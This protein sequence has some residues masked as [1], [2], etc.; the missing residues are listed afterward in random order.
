M[1][2]S[3]DRRK[4]VLVFALFILISLVTVSIIKLT[5][6]TSL[7]SI[8]LFS[9]TVVNTAAWEIDR[10]G[11]LLDLESFNQIDR[12]F[13][14]QDFTANVN[15][16]VVRYQRDW[17]VNSAMVYIALHFEASG[18]V[19]R[20]EYVN[21]TFHVNDMNSHTIVS[22]SNED[23]NC[24]V[25]DQLTN[26]GGGRGN[27]TF[28]VLAANSTSCFVARPIQWIFFDK[29]SSIPHSMNVTVEC[30]YKSGSSDKKVVFPMILRLLK[31][32]G[33]GFS[34]A[35]NVS[36]GTYSRTVDNVDFSDFFA[37]ELNSSERI[38]VSITAPYDTFL[39]YTLFDP[40]HVSVQHEE[41]NSTSVFIYDV[42]ATGTWYIEAEQVPVGGHRSEG[43]YVI[44]IAEG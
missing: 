16:K 40:D 8:G 27:D 31:D 9:T 41:F 2:I 13:T 34:D 25:V 24:S 11:M 15:L 36:F 19:S 1:G 12:T 22:G 5:T 6:V 35:E 7:P 14:D 44:A 30:I 18:S 21:Y 38:S 26:W 37:I 28:I 10:P 20:P 3:V 39:A 42:N 33:S 23:V 17:S 43:L 4:I 29:D 32:A